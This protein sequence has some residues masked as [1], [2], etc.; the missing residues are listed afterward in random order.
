[1]DQQATLEFTTIHKEFGENTTNLN[2][3]D[4]LG[5]MPN[6]DICPDYNE[7]SDLLLD[8]LS[9]YLEGIL[10]SFLASI[11]LM[12]NMVACLVLASKQMRNSFN[13]VSWH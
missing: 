1:M 5:G 8:E 3:T 6:S 10:Q 13:L 4:S 7:E 2:T 12:G 9:F 11:G